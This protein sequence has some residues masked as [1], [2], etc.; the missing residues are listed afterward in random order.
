MLHQAFGYLK[1]VGFRQGL[2]IDMLRIEL[3]FYG[4]LADNTV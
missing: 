1:I 2:R 4:S 3:N